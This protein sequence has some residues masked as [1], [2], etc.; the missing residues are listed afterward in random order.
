MEKIFKKLRISIFKF[1][2]DFYNKELKQILF[3][4]SQIYL[5]IK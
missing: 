3:I 5:L 2:Y 4:H 1:D